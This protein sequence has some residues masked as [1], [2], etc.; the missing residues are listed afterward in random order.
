MGAYVIAKHGLAGLLAVIAA[1]Y[2]WLRVRS[3]RPGYT[4]TP[5]L[6]AFD[7]RFIELQ[8]QVKPIRTAE[9]VAGDILEE[10]VGS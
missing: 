7:A 8:E 3:I 2:S 1:E 6:D 5:M 9:A 10:I 4:R